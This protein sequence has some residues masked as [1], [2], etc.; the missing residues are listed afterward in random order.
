MSRLDDIRARQV[1][2][3]SELDEI[4]ELPEPTEDDSVRT[5]ALITEHEELDGEAAPLAERAQRLAA[6]RAAAAIPENVVPGVPAAPQVMT[7][8]DPFADVELVR[9]TFDRDSI[10]F[11]DRGLR[12]RAISA[13]EDMEGPDRYKEA[14]VEVIESGARGVAALAL[15]TGSPAYRSA[16]EKFLQH[17]QQFQAFLTPEEA[18]AMRTAMSTTV[19]NGGYAIPFLLDPTVI[20]TSNGT[21]NPMRQISRIVRGVSNKWQGLTSAGVTAEWKGEG[22]EAADASPTFTQPAITAY[23]AD[24]YAFG[25]YEIFQDSDLATDL[26][27]LMQD[28]K[29]NLEAD[30]FVVGSGSGAPKGVVTAVTAVTASRVA[31]TTAG[32]FTTA[33][34]AD[35]DKVIEA[36]PPRNR[37][38]AS[39]LANYT[40]Y[41]IIRRMDT[42]GGGSFWANLGAN[43]PQELLG[44]P[45]Y[46]ASAMVSAATTGSNILIAGDFSNYVIYDRIG[47]TVEYIPNVVGSNGRPT[48]QRGFFATWRVGG[49]AV[50]PN[51]FRVLKL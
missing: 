48:A 45:I 42:A 37:S 14:A 11:S 4:A 51:A 2:I 36:V 3:R 25:S 23:L 15:L 30:G 40:T 38:R 44:R 1:A 28:A 18:D 26:P 16:F 33:S 27:M 34:R 49:D 21:T 22:S 35:V 41:G 19:G 24:A 20:L 47:M 5:D 17:P 46:E 10:G 32:T 9:S 8:N 31:P 50:N 6:V 7:R 13:V 12:A 29:D 43:Q 39:W